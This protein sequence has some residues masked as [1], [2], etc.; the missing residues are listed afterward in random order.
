MRFLPRI[1][2]ANYSKNRG[3]CVI[4]SIASIT[5]TYICICKN[6]TL[7][8]GI[9]SDIFVSI[10]TLVKINYQIITFENVKKVALHSILLHRPMGKIFYILEKASKTKL[11]LSLQSH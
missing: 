4:L 10:P 3:K 7:K 11:H 8:D 6:N 1:C 9:I 2:G 5:L